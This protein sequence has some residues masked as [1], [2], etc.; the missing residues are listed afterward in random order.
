MT[1]SYSCYTAALGKLF[2]KGSFTHT[3]KLLFRARDVTWSTRDPWPFLLMMVNTWKTIALAVVKRRTFA[4]VVALDIEWRGNPEP[5]G[6]DDRA[7]S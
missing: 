7:G 6:D 2:G 5:C 1:E 3:M 4:A